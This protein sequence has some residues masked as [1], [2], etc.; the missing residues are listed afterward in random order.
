MG[1]VRAHEATENAALLMSRNTYPM[2]AH[3]EQSSMSLPIFT[4]GDLY[5]TS[6][7][8]VLD[9]I[10]DEIA[11]YLLNAAR[12]NSSDNV[13]RCRIHRD[14]ISLSCYMDPFYYTLNERN[15]VGWLEIQFEASPLQ[16]CHIEQILG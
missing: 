14:S 11:H 15:Q 12:V 13:L 7:G 9:C 8:A 3:A 5:V 4:R 10:T 1:I 6:I 2:I 16:T